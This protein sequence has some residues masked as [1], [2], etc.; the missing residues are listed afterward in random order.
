MELEIL[1]T[2]VLGIIQGLAEFLPVSSS[3]HLEIAKFLLGDTAIGEESLMMTVMLHFATALSTLFVFRKDIRNILKDLFRKSWNEGQEFSLKIILSMIPAGLI[4]FFFEP[5]FETLFS[6]KV[7]FVGLMLLSTAALLIFADRSYETRRPLNRWDALW[8]GFAQA[9]A[10]LPGIS[11]SGSTL[12][13]SL[14]LGVDRYQAARFSFLMVVP[15]IF[16]KIGYEILLGD[17]LGNS[18]ST[19]ALLVGFGFAFV[20]GVLACKWMIR[21]VLLSKLRY[22]GFYCI[23]AGLFAIILSLVYRG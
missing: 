23:A 19:T 16:G 18:V 15:L 21:L 10:L 20:F 1:R 13:T 17:G 11:R 8:I 5:V 3:G 4:G 22:F 12:A 9:V 6:Q 7:G 14:Y 2:A